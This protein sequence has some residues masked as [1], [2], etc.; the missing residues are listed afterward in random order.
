M[1]RVIFIHSKFPVHSAGI[2]DLLTR[3]NIY[4]R[5]VHERSK[6]DGI[7]IFS[8]KI[9][10]N[11]EKLYV[12]HSYIR[13]FESI[14]EKS[15]GLK[16][17]MQLAKEISVS[18]FNFTLVCGDNQQSLLISL[19]LKFMNP[20]KV[21]IQIQFHGDTYSFSS[22]PGIS[23]FLRVIFSR[24][25]INF[26]DS[27]RVVSKFQI[28]EIEA[29]KTRS[30]QEFILAPIPINFSR[31]ATSISEKTVDVAFI[32]RLHPERGINELIQIIETLKVL[33]PNIQIAI[34]GDGPFRGLIENRLSRWIREGSLLTL[35]YLNDHQV[36]NLYG[37]SKVLISSAPREGYG[38]TLREAALS[39]MLIVARDSK[40]AREASDAYPHQ[41]KIYSS[42]DEAVN[43]INEC[44][45]TRSD[46]FSVN[47]LLSQ[48]EMDLN[49]LERLVTSW[50]AD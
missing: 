16:R 8:I 38:L 47:R 50:L 7:W 5:L 22:N 32:G 17:L 25:A 24:L 42:V 27:I 35:G 34:A 39:N 21:K 12:E 45:D 43:F 28:N 29:I 30:A 10:K 13:T 11:L 41:I 48:K 36:Q 20:S 18:T 14:P 40:G 1:R 37:R 2:S 4:G 19:F 44:L 23:G 49:G 46:K 3:W 6:D 9:P 26:S 31:V 33:D 15:V